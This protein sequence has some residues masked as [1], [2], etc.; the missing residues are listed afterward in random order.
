MSWNPFTIP[1]NCR[2]LG[3]ASFEQYHTILYRT[4]ELAASLALLFLH[5]YYLLSHCHFRSHSPLHL[6]DQTPRTHH[7]PHPPQDLLQVT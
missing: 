2:Y 1:G 7:P 3:A 6:I 4:W 5:Y